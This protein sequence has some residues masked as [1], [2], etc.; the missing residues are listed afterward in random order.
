MTLQNVKGF[1]VSEIC[2]AEDN[3]LSSSRLPGSACAEAS[4]RFG[5]ALQALGKVGPDVPV[6]SQEFSGYPQAPEECL[7]D[8]QVEMFEDLGA[9]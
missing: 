8:V 1:D 9:C 6:V 3:S 5:R 2:H 7:V 4:W